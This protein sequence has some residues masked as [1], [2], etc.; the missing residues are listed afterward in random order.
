MIEMIVNFLMRVA[1]ITA[2]PKDTS[3]LSDRCVQLLDKALQIWT[4]SSSN[5]S[6]R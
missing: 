1:L 3:A 5:T 2:D 6:R 4:R